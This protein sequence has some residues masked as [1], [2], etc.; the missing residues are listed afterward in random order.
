MLMFACEQHVSGGVF[1]QEKGMHDLW[2]R[3]PT[4]AMAYFFQSCEMLWG[5]DL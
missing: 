1:T 2:C 3:V 4:V 5:A